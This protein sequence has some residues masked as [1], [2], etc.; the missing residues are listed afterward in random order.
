MEDRPKDEV[1]SAPFDATEL[2]THQ[3]A[4]RAFLKRRLGGRADLDDYVQDVYLRALA[5]GS[6]QPVLN[7]RGFLLRIASSLVID[8]FRHDRARMRSQ[9]VAL[10]ETHDPSDLGAFSPEG[11]LAAQRQMDV[12]GR[13]LEAMSPVARNCF[14]LVRVQGLRPRDAAARLGLTEKAVTRH[15][16]RVMERLAQVLVEDR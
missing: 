14:Q 9:H 1:I 5:T 15:L 7:L 13:A 8:R 3:T 4:L 12:V 11:A 2:T 6:P 10:D 16:E